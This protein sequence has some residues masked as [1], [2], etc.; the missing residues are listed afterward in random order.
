MARGRW[1]WSLHP[2]QHADS[3]FADP[4][5]AAHAD[6]AAA[7]ER[8]AAAHQ[9]PVDP[10]AA[11]VAAARAWLDTFPEQ[12]EAALDELAASDLEWQSPAIAALVDLVVAA[13]DTAQ[14]LDAALRQATVRTLSRLAERAPSPNGEMQWL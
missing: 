6:G 13:H 12:M 7:G 5:K 1:P 14:T 2:G 4:G 8:P 11:R 9:W 3:V 10:G